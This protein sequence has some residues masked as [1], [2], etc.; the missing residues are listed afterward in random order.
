MS[1]RFDIELDD[2]LDND[3]KR[4]QPR[5]TGALRGPPSAVHA[6]VQRKVRQ[7]GDEVRRQEWAVFSDD[8]L[9]MQANLTS[10]RGLRYPARL[11]ARRHAKV[12]SQYS[13]PW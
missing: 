7:G 2:A 3:P 11:A 10:R 6:A 13:Q 4:K 12:C 9:R 8:D 5:L 1:E